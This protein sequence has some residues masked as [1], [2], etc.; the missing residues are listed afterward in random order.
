M[1]ILVTEVDMVCMQ[2]VRIVEV[3]EVVALQSLMWYC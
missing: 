3:A 1:G 2:L